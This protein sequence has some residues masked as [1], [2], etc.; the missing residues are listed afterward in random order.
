MA[1]ASGKFKVLEDIALADIA[2]EAYGATLEELFENAALATISIIAEPSKIALK[3]R[4]ELVISAPEKEKLLFDFLS[5]LVYL[6]DAESLIFGN[7]KCKISEDENGL[8]LNAVLKG[9]R[10][11]KGK[12]FIGHDVK[13]VTYHLFEVRQEKGKWKA[14]VILDI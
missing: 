2:F 5:E 7:V 14:R 13:A 10:V 4:K 8:K 11:T 9:E 12:K 3:V 1:K 6:K